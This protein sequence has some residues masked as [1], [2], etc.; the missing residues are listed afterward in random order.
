M[1][2]TSVN[3]KPTLLLFLLERT[4]VLAQPTMLTIHKGW[5]CN[6][7]LRS[8]NK[9]AVSSWGEKLKQ[10]MDLPLAFKYQ[11]LSL[12]DPFWEAPLLA[13][14]LLWDC[15]VVWH[16][17]W[18]ECLYSEQLSLGNDQHLIAF[19][20][21]LWVVGAIPDVCVHPPAFRLLLSCGGLNLQT[22]QRLVACGN[23]PRLDP[24]HTTQHHPL[25][26]HVHELKTFWRSL[27]ELLRCLFT[28]R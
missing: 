3:I 4:Q 7:V 27:V 26:V 18:L 10:Q 19:L 5:V 24:H 13:C 9:L 15:F 25:R 22:M 20:S 28:L 2:T 8:I 6:R 14:S 11:L 16:Y 12:R 17:T 1:A 23:N 21:S